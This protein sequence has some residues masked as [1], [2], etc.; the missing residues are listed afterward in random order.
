M[1]SEYEEY[2]EYLE[3][4]C[5]R[6]IM[7]PIYAM[8]PTAQSLM[9]TARFLITTLPVLE[10]SDSD[11]ESVGD[12]SDNRTHRNIIRKMGVIA[13]T[14]R[15]PINVMTL[16]SRDS[17]QNSPKYTIGD[18]RLQNKKRPEAGFDPVNGPHGYTYTYRDI[19][20]S[21]VLHNAGHEKPI[22]LAWLK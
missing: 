8:A 11:S 9:S 2:L 12:Y 3:E 1:D 22:Y 6:L 17:R 21:H 7:A 16:H 20:G 19:N 5:D 15:R 10:S 13:D 4:S 18:M 14:V